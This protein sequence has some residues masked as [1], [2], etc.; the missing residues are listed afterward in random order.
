MGFCGQWTLQICWNLGITAHL[1]FVQIVDCPLSMCLYFSMG[2]KSKTQLANVAF[3]P[4]YFHPWLRI[5]LSDV[6]SEI[7]F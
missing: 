3:F 4:L 6:V 7:N 2:Y 1:D 5:C